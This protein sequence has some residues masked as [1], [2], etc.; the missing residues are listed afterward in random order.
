VQGD[1]KAG[2]QQIVRIGKLHGNLGHLRHGVELVGAG[3]QTTL[4]LIPVNGRQDEAEL[5]LLGSLL[6]RANCPASSAPT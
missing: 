4:V 5:T 2:P 1:C 3:D 6:E